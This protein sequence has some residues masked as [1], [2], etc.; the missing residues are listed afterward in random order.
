M[1]EL[2]T[3]DGQFKTQIESSDKDVQ[4]HAIQRVTVLTPSERQLGALKT[5]GLWLAA[6]LISVLIPVL[7]FFLVPLGFGLTCFFTYKALKQTHVFQLSGLKCPKCQTE[8]REN[9]IRSEGESLKVH[10][11]SCRSGIDICT[12][13]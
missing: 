8:L 1:I 5:G 9:T 13:V 3:E 2:A 10:C 11:F 4:G 6:T 12:R 7:H